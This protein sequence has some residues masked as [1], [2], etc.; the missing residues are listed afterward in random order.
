MLSFGITN[1][2]RERYGLND[3]VDK[4]SCPYKA[5]EV[6]GFGLGLA[7]GGAGSLNAGGRTVLYSGEGALEI[8]RA[9][10]GAGL[11]MEETLGGKALN[12]LEALSV[13]LINRK[14]PQEIWD[15]GSAVYAANAKGPVRIFL[16]NPKAG[17]VFN[18]I[19]RPVLDFLKNTVKRFM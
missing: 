19:E 11:L 8:A 7:A 4:T 18:R 13:S 15:V 6:A 12:G 1:R 14:L 5:G 17:S 10:K 3:Y 9:G 16:R 2:I